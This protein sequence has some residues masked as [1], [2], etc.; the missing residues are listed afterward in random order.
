M[1]KLDLEMMRYQRLSSLGRDLEGFVHNAA[2]PLNIILGYIQMLRIKYPDEKNFGKMWDA[3]LEL[4]RMLKDLGNQ[5]NGIND[6]YYAAINVNEVI[7]RQMELLRANNYFKHNIEAEAVLSEREPEIWGVYG[8]FVIILDIILNNAIEAVYSSDV[9]K[10]FVTTDIVEC[11]TGR[12]LVIK[13]RDT[14]NGID[15]NRLSQYFA[16]GYSGWNRSINK[17]KGMGLP[18][19][20]YLCER[21]GGNLKLKNSNGIGA[22]SIVEIP[23]RTHDEI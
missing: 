5:I 12:R 19:G 17:A 11:E 16:E 13:V 21:L 14:G 15:E 22:E 20:Q 10:V 18:L 4:D 9:K 23:L 7:L 1:S 2:G 6:G 8:D 3:G